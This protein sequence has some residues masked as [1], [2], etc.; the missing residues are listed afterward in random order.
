MPIIKK[1][2]GILFM[3]VSPISLFY[4]CK[5]GFEEMQK[6]STLDVYIQWSIFI[7]VF[8]PIVI[9]FFIFGLYSY[10]GEYNYDEKI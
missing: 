1:I 4:L 2:L 5:I 8:I 7:L 9:G 10:K 6:H 3:L